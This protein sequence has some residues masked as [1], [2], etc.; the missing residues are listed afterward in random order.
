M[1]GKVGHAA[2]FARKT[3]AALKRDTRAS[4]LPIMAAGLVPCMAMIG[5]GVDFGRVYLAQS[6][7]Q[8]AVD[9]G[10]LAAVR[11]K[12]VSGTTDTAAEGIGKDYIAANFLSGYLGSTLGEEDVDVREVDKV[13]IADITASG[14]INTTFLRLV[15]LPTLTFTAQAQAQAT[16]TLPRNVEAV[17]VL[18]NTGSMAGAK[19]A[20]LKVAATNFVETVFNGQERREGIAIGMVPYN[21]HVNVGHLVRDRDSSKVVNFPHFTNIS[22]SD[23]LAWKGCVNA[24][25]TIQ[26]V[27]SD[28]FTMDAG[29]YDITKLLPGEDG[30]PDIVP[31][32]YPPIT[33]DSFD[34]RDNQYEVPNNRRRILGIPAVKKA[35][36]DRFDP[37]GDSICIHRN[38]GND[39]VCSDSNA[40]VSIDRLPED[41]KDKFEPT[42][43]YA[44]PNENVPASGTRSLDGPSP[45]YVCPAEALPVEYDRTLS[46]L[47]RYIDEDNFALPNIGTFHT[48]ALVWAY[49]LLERDDFFLRNRPDD[50][51]VNKVI[52]FMTDGIFD[53]RDDG[54][55]PSGGGSRLYDTAYTAYGTYEDRRMTDSATKNANIQQLERRFRKVCEAAKNDGIQLYTIAFRLTNTS[56][57]QLF[58]SCATDPNTHYFDASN[59][60]ELDEA[61]KTIAAELVNL[62]LTR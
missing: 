51:P 25:A 24:D 52:I 55:V 7:L 17:V 1:G 34:Q 30:M 23:P 49:R 27:S 56:A 20:E 48:P 38:T 21:I 11:A 40:I 29:A 60:A 18:D 2:A 42:R 10:A 44:S 4:V 45:N 61:F 26:N 16:D 15:G 8:G 14:T 58:Q 41:E 9:A 43:I 22:R 62:R 35:L 6:K 59:G 13:V 32:A 33:V 57:K 36:M 5:A 50:K 12:Q 28:P 47:K 31:F 3:L 46:S 54:R 37:D 39:L 53:S 19:M